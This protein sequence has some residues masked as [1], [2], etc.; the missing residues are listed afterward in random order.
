MSGEDAAVPHVAE[1]S[2]AASQRQATSNDV[3]AIS[4]I[5]SFLHSDNRATRCCAC[6]LCGPEY[7]ANLAINDPTAFDVKGRPPR[8]SSSRLLSSSARGSRSWAGAFGNGFNAVF[9]RPSGFFPDSQR[10]TSMPFETP[11]IFST[12]QVERSQTR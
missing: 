3:R 5:K 11:L 10:G 1:I 4:P 12:A 8:R 2:E 7:A 6:N 9:V